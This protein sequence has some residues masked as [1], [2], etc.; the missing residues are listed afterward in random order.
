MQN[1]QCVNR[2]TPLAPPL[3]R[4]GGFCE[5]KIGGVVKRTIFVV[6]ARAYARPGKLATNL[7]GHRGHPFVT[8]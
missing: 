1:A 5:A 7:R 6:I 8:R 4:G 2:R 3:V